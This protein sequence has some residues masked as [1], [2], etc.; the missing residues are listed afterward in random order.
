MLRSSDDIRIRILKELRKS[1]V[2]SYFQL[3]GLVKTGFITIK[4]NAVALQKYRF[5]DIKKIPKNRSPSKKESFRLSITKEGL[6]FLSNV[7]E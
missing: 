7:K 4:N 1:P 2:N 6:R 3:S 5:I